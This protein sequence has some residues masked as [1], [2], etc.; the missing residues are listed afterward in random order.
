MGPRRGRARDLRD[1]NKPL[2][3]RTRGPGG[4][5]ACGHLGRDARRDT[6]PNHVH[7]QDPPEGPP[8]H[9]PSQRPAEAF[10]GATGAELESSSRHDHLAVC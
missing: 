4:G 3:T 2:L 7:G 5:L 1:P 6:H 8:F 10:L 9:L